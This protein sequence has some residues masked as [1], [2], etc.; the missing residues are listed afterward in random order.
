MIKLKRL[1]YFSA[2]FGRE[3]ARL[4]H[5]ELFPKVIHIFWAQGPKDAPELV[6]MCIASWRQHNP[7]WRINLLSAVEAEEILPRASMSQGLSIAAYSD[8]LR[9]RLLHEHGGVWADATCYCAKPL[10]DWLP[11]LLSQSDFF[12]FTRPAYDRPLASWFLASQPNGTIISIFDNEI[13]AYI[14]NLTAPPRAYVWLHYLF[15]VTL[16]RHRVL[17]RAWRQVPSLSATPIHLA[18]ELLIGKRSP[19]ARDLQVL[20]VLPLHKLTYKKGITKEDAAELLSRFTQQ[21]VEK[22]Q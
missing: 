21:P 13:A 3:A 17:R 1:G 12:A 6:K 2:V 19:D 4:C 7:G 15:E 8:I 11:W 9:V 18:Q 14:R 22:P 10:D 5:P 16:L 20:R